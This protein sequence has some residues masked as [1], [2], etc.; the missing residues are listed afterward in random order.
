VGEIL[1]DAMSPP[2]WSTGSSTTPPWS[3]SKARATASANAAPASH[4]PL[5]LRRSAAP[6]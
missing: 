2:P 3:P 5:R 1:G 6:P 4:P